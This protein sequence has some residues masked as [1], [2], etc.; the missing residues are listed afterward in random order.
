MTWISWATAQRRAVVENRPSRTADTV[1]DHLRFTRP[2]IPVL[3]VGHELHVV[4]AVLL[5]PR[6]CRRR[7]PVF[8][9]TGADLFD[10]GVRNQD[11]E[12][13]VVDQIEAADAGERNEW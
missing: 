13:Q 3:D 7:G 12:S 5:S 4:D 6:H 8:V 11:C 1:R 10:D 9:L 2:K